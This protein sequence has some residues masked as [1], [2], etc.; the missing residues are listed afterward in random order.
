[1]FYIPRSQ[2]NTMLI[3]ET[4]YST[5]I[6]SHSS[7]GKARFEKRRYCKPGKYAPAL[8]SYVGMPVLHPY[9]TS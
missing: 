6:N 8:R 9:Q 5:S 4:D 3:S 7:Q 1:M 2:A